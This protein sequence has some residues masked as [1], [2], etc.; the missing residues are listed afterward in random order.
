MICPSVDVNEFENITF[1]EMAHLT[2]IMTILL[3]DYFATFCC[4][5]ELNCALICNKFCCMTGQDKST[6]CL[7]NFQEP[8]ASFE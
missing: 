4:G 7:L 3:T 6:V 5:L 1:S 2:T 8:W